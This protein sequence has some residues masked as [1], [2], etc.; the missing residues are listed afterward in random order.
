MAP[1]RSVV[2]GVCLPQ[3]EHEGL[4]ER[5]LSSPTRI[6][7]QSRVKLAFVDSCGSERVRVPPLLVV[8][9]SWNT[10]HSCMGKT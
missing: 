5:L 8:E 1:T 7:T 9:T 3:N 6:R 10:V 2:C 4:A